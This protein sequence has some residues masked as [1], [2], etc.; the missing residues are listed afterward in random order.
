MNASFGVDTGLAILLK[1]APG[2]ELEYGFVMECLKGYK[3]P[4]VKLSHL[5]KIKALIRVKKGIYIFGAPIARHPYSSEVLANMI[6]GPSYISLEWACQYYRLIPEKVTTVTSITTQR[7]RQFQTPL[8]L[9]TYHHFPLQ[10]FPVGVALV[11]LSDKQQALMATKEKALADLLVVRRGKF[12]SKKHFKETLFED[13]RIEE[14][15]LDSLDL[16]I[17]KEIYLARPHSAINYLIQCR[18]HE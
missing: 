12:S 17:L 2:E 6:Y 16:E 1:K 11:K 14:E 9:F 3:N 18:E 4:R 7:S 5:L 13:L 8:G 15:D 10:A